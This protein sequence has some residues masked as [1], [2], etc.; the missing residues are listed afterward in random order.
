[1][2][3]HDEPWNHWWDDKHL[4]LLLKGPAYTITILLS[5]FREWKFYSNGDFQFFGEVQLGESVKYTNPVY[6]VRYETRDLKLVA[7]PLDH[8]IDLKNII[9]SLSLYCL[10]PVW[11]NRFEWLEIGL[12]WGLIR[13]LF[14]FSPLLVTSFWLIYIHW[15]LSF[16]N[17]CESVIKYETFF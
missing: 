11:R 7:V 14:S 4:S 13:F 1:M 10:L 8:C 5:C 16:W 15:F 2:F 17:L 3:V 12:F 9:A 6:F